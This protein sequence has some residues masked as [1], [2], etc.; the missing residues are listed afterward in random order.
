MPNEPLPNAKPVSLS[1][2]QLANWLDDEAEALGG[3][4]VQTTWG[5]AQVRRLRLAAQ[6]LRELSAD[7]ERL[8]EMLAETADAV[9]ELLSFDPDMPSAE[10]THNVC[11]D[12][13]TR[14]RNLAQRATTQES[15]GER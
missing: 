6:R 10:S 15:E 1:E 8:R 12:V 13:L 3:N 9:E 7:R 14:A 11:E 5:K 2:E 4:A